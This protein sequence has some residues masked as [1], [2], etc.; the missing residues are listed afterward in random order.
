MMAYWDCCRLSSSARC[1]SSPSRDWRS[2]DYP[3]LFDIGCP[4]GMRASQCA[5]SR[6]SH[7]RPARWYTIC[8]NGAIPPPEQRL[9]GKSSPSWSYAPHRRPSAPTDVRTIAVS[10]RAP[11]LSPS[12]VYSRT[13]R[14]AYACMRISPNAENSDKAARMRSRARFPRRNTAPCH[15]G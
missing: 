9:E 14:R 7:A 11:C 1:R 2:C 13:A 5:R 4:S 12:T 15:C 8:C 3:S 10:T 6:R